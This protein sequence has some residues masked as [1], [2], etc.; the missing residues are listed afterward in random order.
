MDYLTIEK[1]MWFAI[2]VYWLVAAMFVKKTLKRQAAYDRLVYILFVLLAFSLLFENHFPFTFLY[3]GIFFHSEIWKMAGLVLC[4][5]GLIFSLTAR[6]YLGEN[7]SGTITIKENHQLVQSG[8]YRITRNPIYTGF[9]MAFF[10][11]A[12]SLGQVKGWLGI[13][14]LFVAILVKIKKEEEFMQEIFGSAFQSYKAK[15]KKLIPGLY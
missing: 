15:V 14:F 9:L 2:T 5:A 4:A 12:M 8:P 3:R 11:S 13:I 10:G 1:L 6:I 7:W